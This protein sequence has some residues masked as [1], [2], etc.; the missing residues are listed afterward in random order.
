MPE[1]Q[2]RFEC[3]YCRVAL[4]RGNDQQRFWSLLTAGFSNFSFAMFQCP[5]CGLVELYLEETLDRFLM[6]QPKALP[7]D[8]NSEQEAKLARLGILPGGEDLPPEDPAVA[9]MYEED[10]DE[11]RNSDDGDL[12]VG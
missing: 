6:A 4:Q 9:Q 8:T 2:N 7:A 10:A 12:P 3:R 5:H 1:A 11:F